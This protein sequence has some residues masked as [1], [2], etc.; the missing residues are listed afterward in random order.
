MQ[1]RLIQIQKGPSRGLNPGPPAPEAGIIPLDHTADD[2]KQQNNG[3]KKLNLI[4]EI[5][6]AATDIKWIKT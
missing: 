1:D 5:P 4:Q 6:D 3:A 2:A